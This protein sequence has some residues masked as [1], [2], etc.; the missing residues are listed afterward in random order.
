MGK[1]KRFFALAARY[2]LLPLVAVL[3]IGIATSL[4]IRSV[5]RE[6]NYAGGIIMSPRGVDQKLYVR[7]N[8]ARQWVTIRG[9][10]RNN[11]ILLYLHGGPGGVISGMSYSFQRPW[12]EYFTVVQWDQRGFGRSAIDGEALRGTVTQAQLVNDTIALIEH[13]R[14]KFHQQRIILV[15]HSW[16]SL[17]GAEVARR[18]PD[19]LHAYVGFGQV[20]GW[21]SNFV[22]TREAI[23]R[24]AQRRGDAALA[25]EVVAMGD[26]PPGQDFEALSK[27]MAKV[28]NPVLP[29]R[30]AIYNARGGGDIA[31]WTLLTVLTSPDISLGEIFGMLTGSNEWQKPLIQSAAGW[32]FRRT[33]GTRFAVPMIFVSGRYDLQAPTEAAT[34]LSA[35]ICSPHTE[36]VV[37]DDAA[38][39]LVNEQPGRVLGA[40]R[41]KALPFAQGHVPSGGR[42][43]NDSPIVK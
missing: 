6:N 38:H 15:G 1:V 37:I 41:D 5:A 40:L 4:L 43:C 27:W 7:L 29:L 30:G 25:A 13:L 20:T 8:G 39:Y 26:P 23:R 42:R 35:E 31:R 9:Q 2:V 18:R 19:L 17:L 16:G 14:R 32:D 36:M 22:E 34:A 28:Q 12:E 10:D 33:L 21:E 3:A 24:I 11:P